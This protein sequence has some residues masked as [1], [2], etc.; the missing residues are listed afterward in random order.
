VSHCSVFM[1]ILIFNHIQHEFS[2]LLG[3][4]AAYNWIKPLR[5][6]YCTF[7]STVLR[8]VTTQKN[9]DFIQTAVEAWHHAGT[10]HLI[11]VLHIYNPTCFSKT[12]KR[13]YRH[14]G[15]SWQFAL[16]R[17]LKLESKG[18][19]TYIGILRQV[20]KIIIFSLKIYIN[21]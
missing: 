5:E 4:Y 17:Y 12:I 1:Q 11:I 6:G 10:V 3:S 7:V 16:S 15:I 19:N 20:L 2:H 14:E 8:C 13:L 18:S 9:R 21:C